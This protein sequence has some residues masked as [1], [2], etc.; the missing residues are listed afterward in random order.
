MDYR[1]ET[2]IL[3]EK[4]IPAKVLWG[5]HTAR[6]L[7]N[8]TV[9]GF[10]IPA[11]L[12][13]AFGEVKLACANVNFRLGFLPEAVFLPL[14]QAC[15]E[16]RQGKL[17]EWMVVDAFQG[18]AGTSTNLNACEVLANR[19][20]Q[21]MD[22]TPGEY[23]FCDPLAHVNLHQSTND[24]YPTAL[25][26]AVLKELQALEAAVNRSQEGC[27]S[28][29]KEFAGVLKMARTELMDAV[30]MTL[31]RTFGAWADVLSRDRWRVFKASERLRVVNLGGTAIGT[32][33]GAP[34]KYIFQVVEELKTLTG[35][36][37]ARAENLFDATQNHDV[38][39]ETMGMLKAHAATLMKIS[40]DLRLLAM[41]PE[42]GIAEIELP[43]LQ[44]GSSIMP[45]KVNPVIPEMLAQVGAQVMAA[46]Q[47]V[48][49][50]VA[51]GQL[52]LNAFLPLVAFNMLMSLDMLTRS[53]V[54]AQKKLF[55]GMKANQ[56]HC[57]AWVLKSPAITTVLVPVVG[58]QHA[59]EV[60]RLMKE[61]GL[62][63][64]E[65]AVQVTGMDRK[66]VEV[67]LSPARLNQLGF[68]T[69]ETREGKG[70]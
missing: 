12:I 70:G 61:K 40:G 6:A 11:P 66:D 62:G 10:P 63:F 35:L 39:V 46:D 26:I 23:Q 27:Q 56:E 60:A 48:S 64:I 15:E 55:S 1:I 59:S 50:A 31:G 47:A 65:A 34:K 7:E 19:A 5:I 8:F 57:A 16:M 29:E 17:D 43:A 33:L 24:T 18:G 45:G 3:G 51:S 53:N 36:P 52:E 42:G 21:L 22:K 4:K 68:D 44:A 2:D 14:Q 20:L 38:F 49:W 9:S 30:P 41:G 67:L 13:H 54:L 25:K 69:P 32:G 28:L 37:L 58:Y